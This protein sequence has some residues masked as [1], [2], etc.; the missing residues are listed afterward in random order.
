MAEAII[1]P[2]DT[3]DTIRRKVRLATILGTLQSTLSDFRY[4]RKVWK[5]NQEEERLL[6]VS[7]T[8]IMDHPVMS[9]RFEGIEPEW[10]W[11]SKNPAHHGLPN[12]LTTLKE[13]AIRTNR[14]YADLL[15][16]NYSKQLGL[17]RK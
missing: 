7:F 15:G 3:L 14:E 8:G 4:L 5:Q 10:L 12:V 16:I 1:R 6:G 2:E 17:V 9:G 11:F 13:E